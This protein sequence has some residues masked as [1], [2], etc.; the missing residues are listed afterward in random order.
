VDLTQFLELFNPLPGNRY[1][2]VATK[3]DEITKALYELTSSVDG[4]LNLAIYNQDDIDETLKFPNANIQYIKNLKQPF[5]ALPRDNDIVIFKDIFH[6]H[7]NP[8]IILNI[9]Y[10]TLANAANIII[11]QKNGLMNVEVIKK[12]LEEH[13]FRASNEINILEGYDLVMA[14][15]MHMWGNGL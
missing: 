5:R 12:M 7:L 15:K 2:E 10:K 4:E 13:E 9:A 8:K 1:L 11:I 6:L 3:T 14:K